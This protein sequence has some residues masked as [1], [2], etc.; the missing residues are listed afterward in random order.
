MWTSDEASQ[1]TVPKLSIPNGLIY[2]YTS[3]PGTTRSSR[4]WYLTAVDF[5]TGE[6]VFKILTGTGMAWNNN[7]APITL[8]PDGTAYAGVLNGL[9]AVRDGE[10]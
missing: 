7:W 4:P 3:E 8:G 1:T 2:L 6:T 5:H 10:Q 9:I